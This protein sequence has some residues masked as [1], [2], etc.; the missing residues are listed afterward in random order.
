[1]KR[2][3]HKVGEVFTYYNKFEKKSVRL[4]VADSCDRPAKFKNGIQSCNLCYFMSSIVDCNT[5]IAPSIHE[6]CSHRNRPDKDEVMFIEVLECAV[7][8]DL[9]GKVI[10]VFR[11]G[12]EYTLWDGAH[13]VCSKS[14]YQ[15]CTKP[16]GDGLYEFS[17]QDVERVMKMYE[18]AYHCNLHAVKRLLKRK[19]ESK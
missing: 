15:D 17:D 14:Y 19:V 1:M 13:E 3:F 2:K 12:D 5:D 9:D 11:E 16:V 18:D 8:Y 10:L 4:L 7:R 6:S